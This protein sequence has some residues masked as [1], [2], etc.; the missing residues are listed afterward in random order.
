M[1]QRQPCEEEFSR[2]G[3]KLSLM[4]RLTTIGRATRVPPVL[5]ALPENTE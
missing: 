3:G 1:E 4:K 2:T 5:F